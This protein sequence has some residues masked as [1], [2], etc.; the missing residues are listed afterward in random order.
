MTASAAQDDDTVRKPTGKKGDGDAKDNDQPL[1]ASRVHKPVLWHQQS[2]IAS[3]DLLAGQGGEKHAPRPPFT[4]LEESKS[5]TNPKFDAED[6]DGKKWRVKL[7]DEA[8]PEVAASRLL[9]AVGYYAN[10]DYLLPSAA[11]AGIKMKR[12]GGGVK[13][14][15]VSDARFARKPG[16]QK[17][18]GIWE[19][20]DNPFSGTRELNGLRVMMAVLNNW[21]LKDV[22]NSVYS[23]SKTGEQVFL[24]SDVGA[25]FGSNG[26]A[27]SKA[28]AKG[29]VD[30]FKGS[31]FITST[32]ATTV[33]F[34][35]PSA[36]TTVLLASF[37]T[38]AKSYAM[39]KDLEWIGNDVPIAD[40][41]WM[42]GM[43][44]QLSHRQLEDAFRAAHFP[45][46]AI[47]EYVTVVESRIQELKQ[48]TP[49]L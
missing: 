36:P 16:G 34:G 1:P 40:A 11:V 5:G 24:V 29:N 39:R 44:Q 3:L 27:F 42:G 22:N 25:T 2:A 45:D 10:D 21:D 6:A 31:K 23:D 7:G 9:W 43:L 30:S 41:R 8:R 26:L 14:G 15:V 47:Q 32:T 13:N 38:S 46:D 20:R 28:H 49:K 17:K 35:T 48:L 18:I 12:G 33:S 4:F 37:G 19:W